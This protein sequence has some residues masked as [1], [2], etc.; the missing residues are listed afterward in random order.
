ME[1]EPCLIHFKS[2]ILD[3]PNKMH[4]GAVIKGIAQRRFQEADVE[5]GLAH[6][7]IRFGGLQRGETTQSHG[8]LWKIVN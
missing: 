4:K 5:H 8:I 7:A 3:C 6:L 1:Y 2:Q